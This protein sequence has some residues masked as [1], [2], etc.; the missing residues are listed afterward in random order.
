MLD[1]VVE[2][3]VRKA[4]TALKQ[5]AFVILTDDQNREH[6][7]DLV[8]LAS[9]V[10]PERINSA[11]T[12]ARGVLAVPMSKQRADKLGLRQMT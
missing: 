12:L 9:F 7:G 8:G 4:V 10:T 5:G 2:Q 6:E 3:S 11:L 1:N